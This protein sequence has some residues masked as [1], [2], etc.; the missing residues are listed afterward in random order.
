MFLKT[1]IL[2]TLLISIKTIYKAIRTNKMF[3]RQSKQLLA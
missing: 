1:K 3:L 2:K